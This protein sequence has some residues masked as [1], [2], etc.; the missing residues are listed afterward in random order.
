MRLTFHFYNYIV[1]SPPVFQSTPHT[2]TNQ[3]SLRTMT[4]NAQLDDSLLNLHGASSAA[5]LH[6][7]FEMVERQSQVL[8][9]TCIFQTFTIC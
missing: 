5:L 2:L 8:L 3:A 7:L 6:N 9:H 1:V 4:T